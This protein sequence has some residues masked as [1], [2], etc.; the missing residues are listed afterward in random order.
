MGRVCGAHMADDKFVE[1]G[2]KKG[3]SIVVWR[4]RA[5]VWTVHC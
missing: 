3:N 1:A 4:L 2:Q 5:V